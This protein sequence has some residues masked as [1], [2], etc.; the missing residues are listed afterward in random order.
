MSGPGPGAREGVAAATE[1][2]ECCAVQP[3]ATLASP[4]QSLRKATALFE[5]LADFG[6][7]RIPATS[8]GP[9]LVAAAAC[10]HVAGR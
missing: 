10:T 2:V 6:F 1:S 9:V 3:R 4:A 5:G 8:V 7:V